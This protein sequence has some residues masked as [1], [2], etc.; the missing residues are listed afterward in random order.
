MVRFVDRPEANDGRAGGFSLLEVT[1]AL[2]ILAFGLLGVTAAQLAAMDSS[3]ESR[4]LTQ[5]LYLAEQQMEEFHAMS[6]TEIDALVAD[7]GYPNDPDNPIDPDANDHDDTTYDRSWLIQTDDPEVGISTITVRVD[8]TDEIGV[9]RQVA[10]Q[11][12][13]AGS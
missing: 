1:V 9:D 13:R 3:R 2:G 5:A 10:I 12:M 8:W 7:P 11:S 4:S 6:R